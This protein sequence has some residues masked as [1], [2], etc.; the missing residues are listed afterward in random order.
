MVGLRVSRSPFVALAGVT[1]IVVA[2]IAYAFAQGSM[3]VVTQGKVAYFAS[4]ATLYLLVITAGIIMVALD[5][6]MMV[7]RRVV[8]VREQGFAPTSPTWLLPYI[9]SV[10]KYRWYFVASAVLYG[11]FY[12]FI[13]S[14][15]VYQPTVDFAQAYGA[16]I[17]SAILTPCCGAP[18]YTPVLTVYL[19]NHVGILLIPLT[20]I[21]LIA[22]SS[23]VGL[24]LSMAAFAFENRVRGNARG[25]AGAVGAVAGLFTGCP[26]CA[27]LFFANTLGGS[28]AASFAVLLGYYQ[29][30]FI[31]FSLPVLL[32]T[33]YITSRSLA[34][35]FRDGCVY[36]GAA[37]G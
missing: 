5:L 29:P 3:A 22:V 26:T 31:L 16:S 18:L 36:L 15:L 17:P 28:G 30:A 14:M 33:P 12:S 37:G 32:I 2:T 27:G 25:L 21:L 34:R 23:L 20:V 35:V 7:T 9:L 10:G 1:L 11:L 24:N 13:T 8:V 6:I 4:L 19:A